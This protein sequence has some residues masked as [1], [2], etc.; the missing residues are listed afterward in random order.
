MSSLFQK[1]NVTD[2]VS[3]YDAESEYLTQTENKKL[4]LVKTTLSNLVTWGSA[5]SFKT[6]LEQTITPNLMGMYFNAQ[7]F[8]LLS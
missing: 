4:R 1:T 7:N 5:T 3:L 6:G 8:C 2:N